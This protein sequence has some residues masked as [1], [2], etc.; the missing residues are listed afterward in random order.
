MKILIVDD[1]TPIR[2]WI[3]FSI[4]RA[5]D[6]QLH[7]IAAVQSGEEALEILQTQVIDVVIT[8]IKMPGLSGLELMK[9]VRSLYPYIHFII[10]TNYAEFAY[11]REAVTYGAKKYFLKSELRGED[12]VQTL[13]EILKEDK[14][15]IANKEKDC[16]SNGYLDIYYCYQNRTNKEY[17]K[18]F[19]KRHHFNDAQKYVIL[20]ILDGGKIDA[21]DLCKKIEQ[22][23]VNVLRPA[24]RNGNLYLFLQEK[25][26]QAL[27]IGCN[28]LAEWINQ[29]Y[30]CTVVIGPVWDHVTDVM[31]ALAETDRL[32]LYSFFNNSGII[33]ESY[34]NKQEHLDRLYIQ[35]K[36]REI[37]QQIY[38][39]DQAHTVSHIKLW[40]SLFH[41]VGMDDLEWSR[42][43]CILFLR[44][45]EECYAE[46]TS[47]Y[48]EIRGKIED[49]DKKECLRQCL[50]IVDKYYTQESRK[51]S[52]AIRAT[53]IYIEDHY[54][55]SE[56][57][58][59]SVA[60][61]VHRSSEY[62]SRLFKSEVGQSFSTYLTEYRITKAEEF[63]MTTDMRIYEVAEAIGYPN[64]SYF[65]KIF[66]ETL[67]MT[68][69]QF[70]S[71]NKNR[72]SK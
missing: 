34:L 22:N 23:T 47:S 18:S 69:D 63:L 2:E 6:Q 1:E 5:L 21:E 50:Q 70:R 42:E 31:D 39:K 17:L 32:F 62:L 67:K 61:Y 71:Q 49:L 24:F 58:L 38:R 43:Q 68:P 51:Y 40:F 54:S 25:T 4:E 13:R 35:S 37:L 9:Q 48:H 19:W 29:E 27:E 52:E 56:L 11:A 57:S 44:K 64:P 26:V 3:Q 72:I 30:G 8:D 7:V 16:Y 55:D 36:S 59:T 65:S 46:K 60:N 45:L 28:I 33:R 41:N 53:R 20:G 14:N 15:L 12:I 10:L 66:K